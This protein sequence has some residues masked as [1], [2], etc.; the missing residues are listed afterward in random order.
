MHQDEAAAILW[1]PSSAEV[2]RLLIEERGWSS[3]RYSACLA[4]TLTRVL[5][6]Q[7]GDRQLSATIDSA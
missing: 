1:T 4:G 6:P 3:E 2:H 5:L 7:R